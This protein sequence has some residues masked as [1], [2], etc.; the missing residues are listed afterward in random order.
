MKDYTAYWVKNDATLYVGRK[1]WAEADTLFNSS[2]IYT[3]RGLFRKPDKTDLVVHF[4]R[5]PDYTFTAKVF[6][7]GSVH[8][9]DGGRISKLE[10]RHKGEAVTHYD[11][12]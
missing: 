9:I 11:R 1:V 4:T 2:T 6:D 12:G 3:S 7:L 8:G 5:R 10:V